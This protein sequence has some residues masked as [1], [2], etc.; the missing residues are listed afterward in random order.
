[1]RYVM[2]D[3]ELIYLIHHEQDD[4]A[5]AFMFKKYHK[6]IWKYVHMLEVD[7]KEQDDF[8]QEGMLMLNK[9][10]QSFDPSRNKSFTRYFELIL[11]RQLY[12][13]KKALPEY[14][15]YETT[16]FCTGASYIEEEAE[17]PVFTS[18][19]EAEIHDL[20]FLKRQSISRISTD[21]G[22]SKKQIY[23][24]IFRIKEKYKIVI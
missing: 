19:L 20:Y 24:T 14:R 17:T 22:Y 16:D 8:H 11:K 9:A 10:I 15:L 5:R 18:D 12:K 7:Q 2:N 3:Y 23:N 4:H 13:M 6:F 1:M 21:T